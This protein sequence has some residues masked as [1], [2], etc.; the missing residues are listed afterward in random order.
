M[1]SLNTKYL[2]LDLKNPLVI[3]SSRI[4]GSLEN[5]KNLEEYGAGAIVIRSL[6]EEQVTGEISR[7]FS[8]TEENIHP[9]AVDYVQN[10]LKRVS[11]KSYLDYI[12]KCKKSIG[13][14]I[15]PSLHCTTKGKWIE[16]ATQCEKAGADALELNLYISPQNGAQ[17]GADLEKKYIDISEEIKS[18][19]KIPVAMK[20]PPYFTNTMNMVFQLDQS[21]IDGFV[22]FNRYYRFDFN[23]ED[24]KIIQGNVFSSPEEFAL[25]LRWITLLSGKIHGSISASTGVHDY[26]TFIKLILAGAHTV[27]LASVLYIKDI[28]IIVEI[29]ND[30]KLWM[31]RKGFENLDQFRGLMAQVKNR[32]PYIYERIQFIKN[33]MENG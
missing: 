27:Q 12:E 11:T 29:I 5:C 14:P 21:G 32:Q 4:T 18:R 24:L 26:S 28:K 19:I 3:A 15:I 6:F 1:V 22:L 25:P 33:D 9:E 30:I 17:R 31:S 16:F 13:I 20:L 2:G 7:L 23:I 8:G 10:L